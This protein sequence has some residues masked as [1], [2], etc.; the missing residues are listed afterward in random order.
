MVSAPSMEQLE[1]IPLIED[2]LISVAEVTAIVGIG[3]STVYK[4]MS[5]SVHE[6]PRPVRISSRAVR[7]RLS[8][9]VAW[10]A[11]RPSA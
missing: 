5:S 1:S 4:W 9:I 10:C 8:D 11:E 7:W 3:K 2:R 6:F